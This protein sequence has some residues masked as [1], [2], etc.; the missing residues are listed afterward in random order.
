MEDADFQPLKARILEALD[1]DARVPFIVKR[2]SWVYNF[3]TDAINPRGLWRRTTPNSYRRPTPDWETVLDIDALGAAEGVNWVWGGAQWLRDRSRL[4]IA[5]S[6]G[7]A[8][9][10]VLREFD[11][12][13]KAFVMDG[14]S[15]P[16]SKGS[17]DWLD[18]ESLLVSRD[19]GPG[20]LTT[21]GYPRQVR[22]LKRGGA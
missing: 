16:E 22:R 17:A 7:G 3:W 19:F 2:G 12:D 15:L 9:A 14:F 4:L 5:L 20:T 8:D 1:S 11:V 21:S 10:N 18:A 13:E 6:K